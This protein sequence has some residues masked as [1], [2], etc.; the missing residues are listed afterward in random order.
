M[1]WDAAQTEALLGRYNAAWN[2]HDLAAIL[3]LHAE[4][5]VF[6][7]HTSGGLATDPEAVRK[8]IAGVFATFPDIDFS[9]RR[10]Y[11]AEGFAAVEWTATATFTNP[12]TRGEVTLKP[13]GNKIE[14]NGADIFAIRGGLVARKDVYTDALTFQAAIG[15]R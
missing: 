5:F 4:G 13:T 1:S 3:A 11:F 6:Q 2:A 7:N 10:A 14:W 8:I 15:A 12:I 9:A